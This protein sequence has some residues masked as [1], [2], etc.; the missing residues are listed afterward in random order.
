MS[1]PEY[2]MSESTTFHCESFQNRNTYYDINENGLIY[3]PDS[4]ESFGL[5]WKDIQ[6]I[7]DLPGKRVVI[8]LYN[9]QEVP[10]NYLTRDF[11]ALL[12][13]ICLR[14]S[15]IRKDS[16]CPQKF[17]LDLKYLFQLRIVV[18]LLLLSL[19]IS[20]MVSMVL[21]FTFLALCIPL[22]IFFQRHP[23]SLTVD[24]HS[25]TFHYIFKETAINYNDILR[26]DF[27]VITNDYGGT[28]CI[29]LDLKNKK[30]I[31]IRKIEDIIIFFI[32]VQIKLNE[33]SKIS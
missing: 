31:T 2:D 10:I 17:T 5:V 8:F 30:K 1:E 3:R 29:V 13:T 4:D 23:F 20:L 18:C 27:E 14:L 25:L 15:E 28:L 19:I 7:E 33:N 11:P 22:G 12:K 32:L 26:M 9:T 16:F 6:Y 21:F 24:N